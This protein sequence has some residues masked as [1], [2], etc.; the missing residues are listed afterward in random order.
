MKFKKVAAGGSFDVLHIGHE[1]L[2]KKAFD[3]GE[4]MIIGLT[5][6]E[7]REKDVAPFEKRKK[8]LA[9]FLRNRGEYEII[10]LTDP[11]G[12]AATDETIAAIVVSEETEPG[13]LKINE[14]RKKRGFKPLD[15]ISIPLVLAG[16]G[17]PISST[18]VKKGEIDKDGRPS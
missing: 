7:M 4:V 10:E 1:A 13:A 8:A 2:L 9:L 6:N 17:K 11:F 18:R 14:I 3:V 12:P 15:I 5:S 16:D